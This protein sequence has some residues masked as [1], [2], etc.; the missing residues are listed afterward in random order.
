MARPTCEIFKSKISQDQRNHNLMR[1]LNNETRSIWE[2]FQ[3]YFTILKS[4]E[5]KRFN[6]L[7]FKAWLKSSLAWRHIVW[8]RFCWTINAHNKGNIIF[9]MYCSVS[10]RITSVHLLEQKFKNRPE[11]VFKE[12][13]SHLYSRLLAS[14]MLLKQ[15]SV[16]Q[17]SLLLK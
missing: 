10:T 16:Y 12:Q 5:T 17:E 9:S 14:P 2:F 7:N 6:Y 3:K 11:E 4:A 13:I 15:N 8:T 1:L